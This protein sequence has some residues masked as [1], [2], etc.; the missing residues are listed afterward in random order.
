MVNDKPFYPIQFD[1]YYERSEDGMS[2][3]ESPINVRTFLAGGMAVNWWIGPDQYDF[4]AL[5]KH[6]S[7]LIEKYPTAY[8]SAKVWCQP[9]HWYDKVYPGRISK[10]SD[11]E[12]F[13]YYVY[14][15]Q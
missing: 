4:S 10:Q 7:M 15:T 2:G 9:N 8:L 5:D 12:N 6:I 1:V 3:S 13:P 14:K 11:G